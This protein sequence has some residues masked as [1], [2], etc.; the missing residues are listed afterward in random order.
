VSDASLAGLRVLVT[1]PVDQAEELATAIEAAGGVAIR[2]PAIRISGLE[3][4]VIATAFAA[5]PEPDI[6]IFVS[7][8]AVIHGLSCVRKSNAQLAAIGPATAATLQQ[9]GRPADI[10]PGSGFDSEQLLKQPALQ[11]VRGKR[12]VIV[13]GQSGRAL[14]GDTLTD[15]GASVHYLAV[16]RR[17]KST[18]PAEEIVRLDSAW[19]DHGIDCVTVMSVETLQGLM[20]LL[21]PTSLDRLRETP[22][23]APGERVIQTIMELVPGIPAIKASGPRTADIL[24]ALHEVRHGG[25]Y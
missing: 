19:Q 15:R 11:N 9:A 2:F 4:N 17:E 22:L 14:L 3:P 12:I 25:Q 6:A 20:Q 18:V 7:S 5:L 23:V 10:S 16:Y 8:N 24:N 13:R 1:R 21:P